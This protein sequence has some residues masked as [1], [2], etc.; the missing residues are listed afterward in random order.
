M[1]L[2]TLRLRIQRTVGVTTG[3][4][5]DELTL[6]DSWLH[7]AIE[8]FLVE[9]KSVK[10]TASISLTAGQGDYLLDA[11]ILAFE[12]PYIDPADGSQEYMLESVDSYDIR[13]LRRVASVIHTAPTK[14]AYEA[15]IIMLYPN[16]ASSSDT[17]HLVYVP[18]PALAMTAGSHSPSDTGRGEIRA[19]YHPVLE[20]YAKWKAAEYS[21]DSPSNN[22]EKYQ[23]EWERGVAK[24]KINESRRGGV[25]AGA[26]K[27][28]RR[29][30]GLPVRPGVDLG[31]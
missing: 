23:A 13:A 4:A 12:D 9:T 31:Y 10:K 17:L 20:A 3:S 11:D 29:T 14:I 30:S 26:V 21:N 6:V 24:A 22:G 27:I 1:N 8:Q 15:N 19:E 7:E 2:T 28:G 18:R 16:P 25:R 5:G